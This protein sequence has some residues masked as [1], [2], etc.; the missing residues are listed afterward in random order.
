MKHCAHYKMYFVSLLRRTLLFLIFVLICHKNSR[1]HNSFSLAWVHDCNG[2]PD[3][4]RI[5]KVK[6]GD[7]AIYL[8]PFGPSNFDSIE[9]KWWAKKIRQIEI[10]GYTRL[11][12]ATEP[13]R[14]GF[15]PFTEIDVECN[16]L[17]RCWNENENCSLLTHMPLSWHRIHFA[18]LSVLSLCGQAGGNRRGFSVRNARNVDKS[19]LV[20]IFFAS[21]C[22]CS[23]WHSQLIL[24]STP[25]FHAKRKW[26]LVLCF[27]TVIQH[28][29]SRHAG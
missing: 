15:S 22:H 26:H 11:F 3:A 5:K 17:W 13:S 18:G 6:N 7:R 29:N 1:H 8:W 9:W 10:N 12:S 24:A 2:R 14:W 16:G 20:T 27:C 25:F 4:R 28:M 19:R 23:H 21:Y